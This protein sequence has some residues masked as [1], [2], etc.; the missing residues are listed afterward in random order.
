MSDTILTRS[1]TPSPTLKS[2][3]GPHAIIR[4]GSVSVP[5]YAG[6][7]PFSTPFLPVSESLFRPSCAPTRKSKVL[8]IKFSQLRFLT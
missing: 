2:A 7:N 5:A 8:Q 1:A 3:K 6:T 4:H